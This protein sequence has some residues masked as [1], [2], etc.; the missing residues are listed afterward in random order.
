M[1]KSIIPVAAFIAGMAIVPSVFAVDNNPSTHFENWEDLTVCLQNE[2]G[3]CTLDKDASPINKGQYT[4]ITKDVTLDLGGKT[5]TFGNDYTADYAFVVAKDATLTIV[6]GH[7]KNESSKEVVHMVE[8]A[9]FVL[10]ENADI[11]GNNPVRGNSAKSIVINGTLDGA[12]TTA[13]SVS[14]TDETTVEVN[15]KL[16]S[17]GDA[18][19]YVQTG[20]TAATA[21]G[22]I[23]AVSGVAMNIQGGSLILT[24]ATVSSTNNQAIAF[25]GTVDTVAING[26]S[27][28]TSEKESALY[29]AG[30]TKVDT[31]TINDSTLASTKDHTICGDGAS[32]VATVKIAGSLLKAGSNKEVK[33]GNIEFGEAEYDGAA[34]AEKQNVLS[35][36][37][38]SFG[39]LSAKCDATAAEEEGED[40]GEKTE[41]PNTADTIATYMTIAA[42]APLGLGATAFVAKKSNR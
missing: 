15:G 11:K 41:N 22:S 17:A 4:N 24:G 5:L 20:K 18:A 10:G 7:I 1:K 32:E 12:K 36:A 6:N 9:T 42:V 39:T 27:K 30:N 3:T 33:G 34:V 37:K 38:G 13:L 40:E 21:K 19:A 25:S 31:L 2:E 8:G 14:G 23:S 35:A 16:M 26:C 29:F 28:V